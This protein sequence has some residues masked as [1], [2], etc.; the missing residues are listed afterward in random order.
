MKI[1]RKAPTT[2]KADRSIINPNI[3]ESTASAFLPKTQNNPRKN[4]LTKATKRF[5]IFSI[6]SRNFTCSSINS[7]SLS[8]LVSL[9]SLFIIEESRLIMPNVTKAILRGCSGVLAS[10]LG[11]FSVSF[12]YLNTMIIIP[13][14]NSPYRD[15]STSNG[16][17]LHCDGSH[18]L[19]GF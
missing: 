18:P 2:D 17:P 10:L 4:G 12:R 15:V 9:C 14:Y 5:F 11:T 6:R 8:L 19:R 3:N 13:K 1:Q 16:S 7:F